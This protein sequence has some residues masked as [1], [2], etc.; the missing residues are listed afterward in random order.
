MI[1][2]KERPAA[3]SKHG[4]YLASEG[5]HAI[6]VCNCS[7][8]PAFNSPCHELDFI[9]Q[10]VAGTNYALTARVYAGC[11]V[12][13]ETL[14]VKDFVSLAAIIYQALGE[15]APEV[16]SYMS[17]RVS[18]NTCTWAS[19]KHLQAHGLDICLNWLLPATVRLFCN[20]LKVALCAGQIFGAIPA[21]RGG[22]SEQQLISSFHSGWWWHYF[23]S[24][25]YWLPS[26]AVIVRRS[27]F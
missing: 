26:I 18:Y 16:Q 24:S 21:K 23:T 12:D 11:L 27:L 10:V 2:Q 20:Y 6:A 9:R 7:R 8:A 17:C 15:A 1:W 5:A 13:D 19:A 4:L 14:E 3:R 22:L 25:K